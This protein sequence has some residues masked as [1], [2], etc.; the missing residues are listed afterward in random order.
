MDFHIWKHE[1]PLLGIFDL[2]KEP[3]NHPVLPAVAEERQ[4]SRL[5]EFFFLVKC[6]GIPFRWIE[7]LQ[8]LHFYLAREK[9]RAYPRR[10]SSQIGKAKEHFSLVVGIH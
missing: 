1:L 4:R 2:V 8:F 3:G 9:P 6:P 5:E 10:I 7:K